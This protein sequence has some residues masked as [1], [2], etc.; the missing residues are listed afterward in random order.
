LEHLAMWPRGHTKTARRARDAYRGRAE[1]S[2]N[3]GLPNSSAGLRMDE[4]GHPLSKI[5]PDPQPDVMPLE[6]HQIEGR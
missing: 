5:I 6:V 2:K 1:V 3:Q 4:L